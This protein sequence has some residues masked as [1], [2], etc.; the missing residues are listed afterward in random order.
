MW[1]SPEHIPKFR[2]VLEVS[3]SE[4]AQCLAAM[5]MSKAVAAHWNQIP[6]AGRL[7]LKASY[8]RLLVE[9]APT[10]SLDVAKAVLQAC[11]QL[12]RLAWLDDPQFPAVIQ[13]LQSVGTVSARHWLLVFIAYDHLI[14]EMSSG[15]DCIYACLFN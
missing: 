14:A 6:V 9:R 5:C 7:E 15:K 12:I 3:R 13:E 1:E 8:L 10:M 4:A 2:C 11:A